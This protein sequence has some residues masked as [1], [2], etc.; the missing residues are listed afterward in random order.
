MILSLMCRRCLQLT[1]RHQQLLATCCSE[2]HHDQAS[3]VLG[4]AQKMPFDDNTFNSI[5]SLRVVHFWTAPEVALAEVRRILRAGGLMLMGCL[6]PQGAPPFA[7]SE[8]GFH[9]REAVAWNSLCRAAG[10]SDTKVE[11]HIIEQRRADGTPMQLHVIR[12]EARA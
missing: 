5:F 9:L 1:N 4:S 7:R 11:N 2:R 8:Y 6:A 12:M 3:F 10:F